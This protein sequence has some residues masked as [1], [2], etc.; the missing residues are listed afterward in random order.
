MPLQFWRSPGQGTKDTDPLLEAASPPQIEDECLKTDEEDSD[1]DSEEDGD[2]KEARTERLRETGGWLGYLKDFTIF[3]PYVIPKRDIKVQ[4]CL[5][6]CLIT[7]AMQRVLHVAIPYVLGVIADKVTHGSIP[8]R[9]LLVFL[10]FDFLHGE[11]GLVFVQDL[12]KIPIK[13]FSYKQLTNAAFCHVMSQSIDFHSTQDSAEVMKAVEQGEALGNVLETV[14]TEIVPTLI[15]VVIAC[16]I[17]YRKFTPVVGMVLLGASILYLAAEA[18]STRFTTD[19]RRTATKA[20]RIQIR[21]MHQAIQGWQTVTYFNQF[22]GEASVFSSAVDDHMRAKKRFEVRQA[23]VKAL[24]ELL[25]P[26]TFFALAYLILQRI[27]AGTASPGDFV[28]FLTY[29]DSIIYPL[30]F[31][32]DHVR[33]LVRDF[34]DAERVLHLLQTQ[35]SVMDAPAAYPLALRDG[36]VRFLDV[37]FKYESTR[38]ALRHVSFTA[39]LGQTVALVGQTGAGKSSILKLLLRLH[40]VTSGSITISEKDIRHITLSSLRDAVSVVPQAPTFFNTSIMENVRYARRTATDEQVYEVCRAAAIH[41]TIIRYPKGYSTH[42]GER[43]VKL[44]GGEAQRLAIARALLKD[45][46]IVL[47]DEA[48]SAVDT[49]TEGN[50][51]RALEKLKEGRIVIVIAHRLSTIVD[52]DLIL[53][54]HEGSIVERGTHEELYEKKGWYYELQKFWYRDGKNTEEEPN[55]TQYHAAVVHTPISNSTELTLREIRIP[56]SQTNHATADLQCNVEDASNSAL[57]RLRSGRDD[58]EVG[59]DIDSANTSNI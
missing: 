1:D 2:V 39:S 29:W 8:I 24:V 44:S 53:V 47:L 37:S 16:T 33:W 22:K 6:I 9:E 26:T 31:L 20:E 10:A 11:S 15:D 51:K 27:A 54:M 38:Y 58:D 43:G 21:K 17:F 3:L 32:T 13:Q 52:A 42:V 34:V 25:V 23:L 5:L 55:A 36:E 46:P 18:S 57:V 56:H 41:D 48:T 45:A 7:I 35:P 59:S 40:D 28:F 30:K 12:S 19:D 14:V 49:V 4:T 50:I